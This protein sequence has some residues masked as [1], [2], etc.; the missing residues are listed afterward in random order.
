MGLEREY[1]ESNMTEDERMLD[2]F[3]SHAM[4]TE[5]PNGLS[6]RVWQA[7][8]ASIGSTQIESQLEQAYDQQTPT[9]LEDRVFSSTLDS[10]PQVT[11]TIVGRVGTV[12]RWQQVAIAAGLILT[13]LI[14]IRFGLPQH[15]VVSH[16]ST[17]AFALLSVEEESFL[18]DDF[19]MGEYDY[20]AGTR[21]LAFADV[22]DSFNSVR[23]DMELWQYGLLND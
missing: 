16:N 14:A 9:G 10:L 7:S 8:R 21:E 11:P 15:A 23:Q 20:L 13:T 17:V 5:V 19:E 3:L 18:L 1:F 2:A 6:E 22:A 4:Q 12:A